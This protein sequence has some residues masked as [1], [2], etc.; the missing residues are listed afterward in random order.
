MHSFLYLLPFLLCN[1]V[2]RLPKYS[3][4]VY[5]WSF[6]LLSAIII[7]V[8]DRIWR[9]IKAYVLW[10]AFLYFPF[11]FEQ[12]LATVDDMM[13]CLRVALKMYICRVEN[14]ESALI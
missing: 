9:L 7:L 12:M 1:C 10:Y 8:Y 11:F 13:L 3:K 6:I 14:D 4:S 2:V 5:P